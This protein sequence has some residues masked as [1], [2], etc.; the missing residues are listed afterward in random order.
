MMIIAAALAGLLQAT[1]A[2]PAVTPQ[3][4]ASAYL[5]RG[6]ADLLRGARERRARVERSIDM[7]RV[8]ARERVHAG[9]EAMT[10]DRTL[11]GQET[12]VRIEWRRGETGSI[13]VLGA[14]EAA[15]AADRRA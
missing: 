4:S 3:D 15:P 1:P 2:V 14:R 6:A 7:Y 11:F 13:Q 5:D 9:V 8:T 12:A 10:R